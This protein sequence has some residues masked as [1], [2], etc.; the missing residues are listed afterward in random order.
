M[1]IR[2]R[3]QFLVSEWVRP[4]RRMLLSAVPILVAIVWTCVRLRGPLDGSSSTAEYFALERLFHAWKGGKG[5]LGNLQKAL[6]RRPELRAKYG[7]LVAQ[8]LITIKDALGA[9]RYAHS[10][11]QLAQELPDAYAQFARG[12]LEVAKGG[13]KGGYEAALEHAKDLKALLSEPSSA[14]YAFTLLRIAMLGRL[15]E[16]PDEERAALEEL[17]SRIRQAGAQDPY[18]KL[19]AH[20]RS[21]GVSFLDYVRERLAKL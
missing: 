6:D 1:S 10:A 18:A 20:M 11:W 19:S 21:E 3:V 12:S 5:D 4:Y 17:A 2:Y 13:Y 9:E 7:A 16:R 15:T 14:L 8:H